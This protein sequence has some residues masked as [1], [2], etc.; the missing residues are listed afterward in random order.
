[1]LWLKSLGWGIRRIARE[2]GCS[3][4]TVRRYV[5]QGGWASY[6]QPQRRQCAI[7][8]DPERNRNW[9][10]LVNGEALFTD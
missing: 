8:L 3:R 4:M 7:S 2:L 5:A 1:M 6:R 10:R 9:E